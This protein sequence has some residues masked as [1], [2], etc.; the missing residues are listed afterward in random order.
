MSSLIIIRGACATGKS[1][2]MTIL[3]RHLM[4][5][6]SYQTWDMKDQP[7]NPTEGV[8]Y[9]KPLFGFHFEEINLFVVAKFIKRRDH[10]IGLD[11]YSG[12]QEDLDRK[13][14]EMNSMNV[15][16]E[17]YMACM[18][19][20]RRRP[21]HIL[22]N[23]EYPHPRFKD[24]VTRGPGFEKMLS[25]MFIYQDISEM[26]ARVRGRGGKEIDK[27]SSSWKDSAF[28]TKYAPDEIEL[29]PEFADRIV[30]KVFSYEADINTIRDEVLAYIP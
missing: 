21:A 5:I 13:L 27:N 19:R 28:L 12:T 15:V 4:S 2:R 16:I 8:L 17:A 30:S 23:E 18:P 26:Q 24:Q 11:G 20:Y 9:N 6:H 14:E 10:Y 29:Y 7:K 1:T 25:L 22:T 3:L